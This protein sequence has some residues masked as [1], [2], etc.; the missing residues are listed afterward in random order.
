MPAIDYP[1][2]DGD[3]VSIDPHRPS[4]DNLGGNQKLDDQ[5]YPPSSAEPS[6][7]E[8][9]RFAELI[10]LA[11]ASMPVLMLTIDFA[12]G[13]PYIARFWAA[14]SNLAVGDLTVTDLG[15]G[16]TTIEYPEGTLPPAVVDPTGTLN[17]VLASNIV[18]LHDESTRTI[19]IATSTSAGSADC[20]CTIHVH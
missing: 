12:G 3:G 18:V 20:R 5:A 6:A 16:T 8:W 2:F 1:P 11:G 10:A 15:P 13:D 7:D 19:T 4:L 17:A 9:N 14:N